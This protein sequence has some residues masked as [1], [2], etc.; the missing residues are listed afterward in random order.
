LGVEFVASVDRAFAE[1]LESPNGS[2]NGG[3][4]DLGAIVCYDG[5]PSSSGQRLDR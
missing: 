3:V 2:P 5:F 4:I 1:I